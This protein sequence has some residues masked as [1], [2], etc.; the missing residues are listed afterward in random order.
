M[1]QELPTALRLLIQPSMRWMTPQSNPPSS[2]LI[3]SH[4]HDLPS[5]QDPPS[6]PEGG[7]ITEYQYRKLKSNLKECLEVKSQSL[8]ESLNHGY[9]LTRSTTICFG[10]HCFLSMFLHSSSSW[11]RACVRIF[12]FRGSASVALTDQQRNH[13]GFE[14]I[15]AKD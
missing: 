9:A 3:G 11:K 6:S 15:A 8:R 4:D 7:P 5:S 1:V 2:P 13:W 12:L 10:S 14:P